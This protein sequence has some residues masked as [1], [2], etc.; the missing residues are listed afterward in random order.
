MPDFPPDF[1]N[2]ELPQHPSGVHVDLMQAIDQWRQAVLIMHPV[3]NAD[4]VRALA[5]D[6]VKRASFISERHPVDFNRV[7]RFL[8]DR[9][10]AWI[11]E[12]LSLAEIGPKI[13]ATLSDLGLMLLAEGSMVR[14]G[15]PLSGD[16]LKAVKKFKPKLLH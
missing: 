2:R 5:E 7:A 11:M 8:L 10:K 12:G 1:F 14:K 9:S 3:A 6:I 13:P 15:K 4:F 16:E